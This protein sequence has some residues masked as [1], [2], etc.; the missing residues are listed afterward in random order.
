MVKRG[1]LVVVVD[2][3]NCLCK[4]KILHLPKEIQLIKASTPSLPL[5]IIC[6]DTQ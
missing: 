6:L 2:F 4:K 5:K 1:G 3:E